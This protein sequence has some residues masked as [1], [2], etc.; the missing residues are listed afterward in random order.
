MFR[1][2]VL[3]VLALCLML[4]L[5]TLGQAKHTGFHLQLVVVFHHHHHILVDIQYSHK[6]FTDSKQRQQLCNQMQ[7]QPYHHPNF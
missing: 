3:I 2:Q 4:P 5:N 6:H 1:L 7:V